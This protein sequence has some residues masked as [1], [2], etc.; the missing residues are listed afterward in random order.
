MPVKKAGFEKKQLNEVVKNV[1]ESLKH[2]VK[3]DSVLH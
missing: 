2:A 3:N 1:D